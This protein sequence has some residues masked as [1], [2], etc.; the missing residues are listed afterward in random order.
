MRGLCSIGSR[1][2]AYS[3]GDLSRCAEARNFQHPG[4]PRQYRFKGS[5]HS[6]CGGEDGDSSRV[7][8]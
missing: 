8:R 7:D 2:E 6:R 1:Q 5:E 3:R 4:C